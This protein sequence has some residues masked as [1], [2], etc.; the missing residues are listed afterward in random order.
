MDGSPIAAE[1]ER[2]KVKEVMGKP[3]LIPQFWANID[4]N[5]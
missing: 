1:I 5:H 2:T 3:E 4:P